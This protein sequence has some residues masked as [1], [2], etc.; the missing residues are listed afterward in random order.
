M[1]ALS[2]DLPTRSVEKL[3][4]DLTDQLRAENIVCSLRV[5]AAFR[6]VPRE[7]FIRPPRRTDPD[8]RHRRGLRHTGQLAFPAH[9]PG[10]SS[11]RYAS[12]AAWAD[13]SCS[14][15]TAVEC[16]YSK[17]NPAWRLTVRVAGIGTSREVVPELALECPATGWRSA[18]PFTAPR[19]PKRHAD[20]PSFLRG[21]ITRELANRDLPAP[22]D[23]TPLE[24]HW[25]AWRRYRPSART[26]QDPLQGQANRASAFLRITFDEP[27]AG[28]I[29]LGHLSHFGLGLFV[30]ER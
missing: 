3:R 24:G 21:E 30:P 29:A 20:W 4:S 7:V 18:T 14:S 19:Y 13:R 16:L 1:T 5:E 25:Q 11:R 27:V 17:L 6:W 10:G 8:H 12:A 23:V 28:P 15:L 22:A 2:D 26:R 9:Q